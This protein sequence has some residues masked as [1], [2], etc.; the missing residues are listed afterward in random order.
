MSFY[1]YILECSNGSY[2][3]GWSTDPFRRLK[4]H[5]AGRG[6]SYTRMHLPVKLV[7][8]EEQP[9]RTSAMLRE[10]QIKTWTHQR[11]HKL[12]YSSSSIKEESDLSTLEIK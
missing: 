11:K 12:I 1:C 9:D 2:Y 8:I 10:I 3:T 4:Q 7:F 6:A 5:N